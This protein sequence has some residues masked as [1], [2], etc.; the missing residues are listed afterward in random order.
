MNETAFQVFPLPAPGSRAITHERT[1]FS[2][3]RGGVEGGRSR[4]RSASG[5]AL[6]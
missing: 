1:P 2:A 3:V 5:K 4:S 6:A